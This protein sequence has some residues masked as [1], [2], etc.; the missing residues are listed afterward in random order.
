MNSF[1]LPYSSSRMCLLCCDSLDCVLD[2]QVHF[3]EVLV[4]VMLL[5]SS[6]QVVILL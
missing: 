2:V 1:K 3:I 4:V 5:S 6:D